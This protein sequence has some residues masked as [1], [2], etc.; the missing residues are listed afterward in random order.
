MRKALVLIG[1]N[2]I[3][4]EVVR[5]Y[6]DS[7]MGNFPA[8]R[9][10]IGGCEVRTTC[11]KQYEHLEPWIQWPS[12]HSGMSF[13][14]HGLFRLGDVV[15]SSVPQIFE[16]LEQQGWRV[17]AIS[18]MNAANR[19]RRPAYFVPDPWTA[20]PPDSSWWSRKLGAAV[21]QA[22]NDNARARIRPLS[23]LYLLCGLVRFARPKNYLTYLRLAFGL[24]KSPWRKAMSLDLFLHDLHMRRLK[25][26]RPDFS[27][28]FLNGGAHIQHHYFLNAAPLRDDTTVANPDWYVRAEADPVAEMLAVYDRIVADYLALEGVEVIV[29]TGLS[30]RPYDRVKFYYRLKDHAGFLSKIGISFHSATPRMTRDFL[31]EFADPGSAAKAEQRLRS[32][33]VSSGGKEMPLF[34][35][36]DNRGASL[37]ITL[38]YPD[39]INADTE[40]ELDGQRWKLAP[41]VVFVA[42]KNGMHQEE[43]FAYFSHGIARF[44]PENGAHVKLLHA[45]VMNYFATNKVG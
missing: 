42:I 16:Q 35:E 7:G 1:L 20:T 23:V 44:A 28:L 18:P 26:R 21:S 10:L 39:E 40:L 32:A 37:F 31:V 45:A 9:R 27:V 30:Q 22:V 34:G 5:R 13:E 19:L 17:G 8:L 41:H 43:G 33:L 6:I 4:F 29:A 11:E 24:R 15:Q 14:E 38:T 3:N 25:S 12:V 36:I 2:E